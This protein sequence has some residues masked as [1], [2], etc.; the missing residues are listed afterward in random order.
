[1]TFVKSSSESFPQRSGSPSWSSRHLTPDEYRVLFLFCEAPSKDLQHGIHRSKS[2][3]ELI[4]IIWYGSLI[5]QSYPFRKI[6]SRKH[7]LWI[8]CTS[9]ILILKVIQ[10][11][12]ESHN[13]NCKLAIVRAI[14]IT[15]GANILRLRRVLQDF[16]D[17]HLRY[18]QVILV[19][20]SS[21]LVGHKLIQLVSIVCHFA[22]SLLG[23]I[24]N[25]PQ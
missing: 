23:Q 21:R 2:T 5:L 1:M 15:A 14:T 20:V 17:S 19:N 16:S 6:L 22:F 4:Y 18:V 25:P 12:T 10:G 3:W 7:A 24:Q 11:P 8:I 13:L 9:S